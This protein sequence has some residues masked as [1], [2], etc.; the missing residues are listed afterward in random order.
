MMKTRVG[1]LVREEAHA[2]LCSGPLPIK[3]ICGIVNEYASFEGVRLVNIKFDGLGVPVRMLPDGRLVSQR[4]D[5]IMD[6]WKDGKITHSL[7]ARGLACILLPNNMFASASVYDPVRVFDLATQACVWVLHNEDGFSRPVNLIALPN[8]VLAS[9]HNDG[10]IRIWSMDTGARLMTLR[11]HYKVVCALA[12]LPN[13][14]LASGSHDDTVR[15]WDISRER[16]VRVLTGHENSVRDLATLPDGRLA[17]CGDDWTVRIWNPNNGDCEHVLEGHRHCVVSLDVLSD[18]RLVS[19][20]Y[21]HT[22][23]VWNTNTGSCIM[24]CDYQFTSSIKS[25]TALPN[26]QLA[27]ANYGTV[28]IWG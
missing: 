20:A 22:F 25:M 3:E 2:W 9:C 4:P 11:E 24:T 7:K 18:G 21:D 15:I 14:L 16:C 17:S 23:R 8:N 26:C 5:H 28:D 1:V 10:T 19:A 13:G 12:S 27:I 6:I